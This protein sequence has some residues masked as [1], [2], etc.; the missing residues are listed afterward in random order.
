M[1]VAPLLGGF[2]DLL[3]TQRAVEALSELRAA[4][5]IDL[6]PQRFAALTDCAAR[7]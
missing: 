1:S 2:A 5:T 3:E 4:E 6:A 7:S